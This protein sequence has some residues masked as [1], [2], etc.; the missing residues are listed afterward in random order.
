MA[1]THQPSLTHSFIH[2]S[3]YPTLIYIYIYKSPRIPKFQGPKKDIEISTIN[4]VCRLTN[5]A[6]FI[7]QGGFRRAIKRLLQQVNKSSNPR[8]LYKFTNHEMGAYIVSHHTHT[9]TFINTYIRICKCTVRFSTVQVL[10]P[11]SHLPIFLQSL[12]SF[13][14]YSPFSFTIVSSKLV[15]KYILYFSVC[16]NKNK[17]A[18]QL[19]QYRTLPQCILQRIYR[20][21]INSS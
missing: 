16:N 3:I 7:T 2:T 13:P 12:P 15:A 18:A 14:S 1:P 10:H 11:A 4:R 17:S 5:Q 6:N 8:L 19:S 21:A 20:E 9:H